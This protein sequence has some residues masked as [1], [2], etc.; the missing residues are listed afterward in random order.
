[1]NLLQRSSGAASGRSCRSSLWAACSLRISSVIAS[2]FRPWDV[3]RSADVASRAVR[4]SCLQVMVQFLRGYPFSNGNPLAFV[5]V[6]RFQHPV[7]T[8]TS[9]KLAIAASNLANSALTAPPSSGKAF[10]WLSRRDARAPTF[11]TLA[12][13]CSTQTSTWFQHAGAPNP[14]HPR[15]LSFFVPGAPFLNYNPSTLCGP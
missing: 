11:D 6:A 14:A 8:T 2:C 5:K 1:M 7:S 10:S 9:L 4:S 3:E 12:Q 13:H 15:T